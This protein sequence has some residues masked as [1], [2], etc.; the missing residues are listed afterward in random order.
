MTTKY[1]PR[2]VTDNLVFYVD[3]ANNKSFESIYYPSIEAQTV[4]TTLGGDEFL[5]PEGVTQ[6]SA[7]CI[8]GGG[9]GGS[10]S[11]SE[12]GGGGG[13]GGALA[14]G[15]IDVTPDEDLEISVGSG[16]ECPDS[17]SDGGQGTSSY[18]SRSGDSVLLRGGQGYG[19]EKGENGGEGGS[20]G[21]SSGTSRDGGGEGGDGGNAAATGSAGGGG[22]GAG[23]YSGD[24]GDGS[25]TVGGDGSGGAGGGGGGPL[26]ASWSMYYGGGVGFLGEHDP[27]ENGAGGSY[28]HGEGG[29]GGGEGGAGLNV[30]GGG[31]GGSKKGG[32]SAGSDGAPGAV[33]IVYQLPNDGT[34]I[35]PAKAGI[36]STTTGTTTWDDL[37]GNGNNATPVNDPTYSSNNSGY[38]SFNGTDNKVTIPTSSVVLEEEDFTIGLWTYTDDV[39]TAFRSLISSV[40]NT[41]GGVNDAGSWQ[42]A[43]GPGANSNKIRFT[44]RDNDGD[45]QKHILSNS[46]LS[47]GT[48]YYIV[49]TRTT[50]GNYKI[51]INGEL[52][53]SDTDNDGGTDLDCTIVAFGISRA[54]DNY[55]D[56]GIAMAQIY[57]GKAL[58]AA[59]VT[60][61]FDATKGRYV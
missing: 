33:R 2:I 54:Y 49:L 23:G 16:G 15:T 4:Y 53:V 30:Y 50:G 36:G 17:S 27:V 1:N 51:Y 7:V 22:G 58:S 57:K 52:D 11:I 20:G 31:G 24:G 21:T 44:V 42:L 45:G 40:D 46:T 60:Q 12:E 14:Y 26:G 38:L 10:Y 59:E 28:A 43:L 32:G 29:S 25:S 48:W 6:I 3:V 8:G 55:W 61:N 39:S 41:S 34:R 47:I 13:G 9:A 18:I 5:V 37:S 35:Y 19:G 56:G